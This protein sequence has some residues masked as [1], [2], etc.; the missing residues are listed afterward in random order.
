MIADTEHSVNSAASPFL[1]SRNITCV[2]PDDGTDRRLI[3][4]LRED[5]GILTATSKTCRG[6]G[7]LRHCLTKPGRLPE[8]ELVRRVDIVVP[9]VEIY[10][11]FEYI[12]ELA[13]IGKLGG[14]VMWLGP[15]LTA[16]SFTLPDDV[17]EEASHTIRRGD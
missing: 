8:S 10:V 17:P 2:I 13:G 5:K 6:I 11:L 1:T 16:T 4:S 14:G 12:H 3:Q 9:D 7:I 15:A